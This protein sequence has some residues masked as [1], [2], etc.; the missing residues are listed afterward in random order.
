MTDFSIST[1][2]PLKILIF[3][4]GYVA[5]CADRKANTRNYGVF[6]LVRNNLICTEHSEF[7]TDCE[8]LWVNLE[9]T[10][11]HPLYIGAY[12]K[13]RDDDLESLSELRT[14]LE[15]VNQKN[16]NVWL[17]GDFNLT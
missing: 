9:V 6:I 4:S 7:K 2:Q 12:Y 3:S 1:S 17:L 15:Q 5:F 14:S 8:L 10:G 13:P 11:S 16:G